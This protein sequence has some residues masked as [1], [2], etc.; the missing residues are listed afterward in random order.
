MT[1]LFVQ[2]GD[3]VPL[4]AP[5]DRLSGQGAQVGTMFGV[6]MIDVLNGITANFML[7]GVH[8]LAKSTGVNW[9]QGALL[10]WDNTAKSVTNVTTSNTRIGSALQAQINGDTTCL[11]RLSGAPAPTGA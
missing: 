5:Y 9:V 11:I 1:K 4:A 10:Y 7:E 2:P 8:T 6:A 3:V